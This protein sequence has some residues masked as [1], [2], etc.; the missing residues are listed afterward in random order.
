MR[1]RRQWKLPYCKCKAVSVCPLSCFTRGLHEEIRLSHGAI[2]ES[3]D[4][5][6]SRVAAVMGAQMNLKFMVAADSCISVEHCCSFKATKHGR[7]TEEIKTDF[8]LIAVKVI[9]STLD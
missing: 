1:L 3:G 8:S 6:S 5:K 4:L 9:W 2:S 7:V